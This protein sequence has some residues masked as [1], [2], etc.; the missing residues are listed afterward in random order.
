M[1]LTLLGNTVLLCFLP[2]C[3]PRSEPS[4]WSQYGGQYV[5]C[6]NEEFGLGQHPVCGLSLLGGSGFLGLY[7]M[8]GF[9]NELW[10]RRIGILLSPIDDIIN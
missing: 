6:G 5:V 2:G 8:F 7:R 4:M 1:V 9:S 3:Q 10:P